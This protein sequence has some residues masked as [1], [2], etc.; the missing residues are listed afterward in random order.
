[1]GVPRLLSLPG[2]TVEQRRHAVAILTG[3]YPDAC[4]ELAEALETLEIT[5]RQVIEGGGGKGP[6]TQ[7]LERSLK[8]K[9]WDKKTFSLS[10]TIDGR[11]IDS[12][13]HEID[14][15]KEFDESRPGIA[16]EI[17]W[18]NKDP[19]YDRDL[20]AFARLHLLGIISVGV[21]VTRGS[22]LR[23]TLKEVFLHHYAS[24]SEDELAEVVSSMN[25][26]D[27]KRVE[28]APTATKFQTVAHIKFGSKYGEATTHWKKLI[29]RID[30]GLGN[31]CPLLLIGIETERLHA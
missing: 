16:L 30:R 22:S 1:M 11:V 20:G 2:Y 12:T 25:P 31:P 24:L 6:M 4:D 21:I 14:H 18:N 27:K 23:N 10:Q 7:A 15:F 17:E 29:E 3:D 13:T 26:N 28:R 19:F 5:S 8:S 9:G